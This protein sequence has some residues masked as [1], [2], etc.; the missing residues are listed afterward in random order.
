MK[1]LILLLFSSMALGQDDM[2]Q[3]MDNL[4]REMLIQQYADQQR[5]ISAR[6]R[7]QSD[8]PADYNP[9]VNRIIREVQQRDRDAYKWDDENE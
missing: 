6:Q 8:V 1:I 2:Q 7:M 4:K 5:R 9:E 3:Q